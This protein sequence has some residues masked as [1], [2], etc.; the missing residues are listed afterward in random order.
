MGYNILLVNWRDI[1]H[2]EAGGAEVHAH[3][4]FR[5]LV[6][7]GHRV[8]FL[9]A[10]WP[11]CEPQAEIDGIRVSRVGRNLTFN[12]TAA[13][14]L[15]GAMDFDILVEDVNKIPFCG[16]WVSRLPRL[17]L[18]HHL[19]GRTIF[20]EAVAPVAAYVWLWE[21]MIPL[22][23]RREHVQA[24]SVDTAEELV[25]LG[26]DR[27]RVRVVYNGIDSSVYSPAPPGQSGPLDR[28]Y[29]LYMGRVKRYKRLDLIL[30]AF[31][32]AARSGLDPGVRLVFAGGGDDY[33]R[34]EQ[35]AAALGISDRCTFSGRVSEERKITLLRHALAVANPSPKEGWGITNMEAAACGTPVVAS[36]SPGLRESV[37]DGI[38]GFLFDP[39]DVQAFAGKL[40]AVAGDSE[41]RSR[42]GAGA[43]EF[44]LEF[45]WDKS[46]ERTLEHIA[47]IVE[48]RV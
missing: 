25:S 36:R 2:P 35:R 34:L 12:Y 9:C 48:K 23:Y 24:V 45:N 38:S 41:L 21:Q 20:R 15:R 33:P 19:F 10:A 17:V 47:D 37:R 8:S 39:G 1:A 30:E 3:E 18:F 31:S 40:L 44:A 14:I 6:R 43:R 5:R 46:A 4:I 22:I 7:M 13:R 26:F 11:G 16:P 28:P 29:I 32:I 42:L 27:D